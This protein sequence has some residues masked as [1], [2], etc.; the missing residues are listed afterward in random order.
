MAPVSALTA[1]MGQAVSAPS[2]LPPTLGA[3]RPS[4]VPSGNL[5]IHLP[6][7]SPMLR[8]QGRGPA[9]LLQTRLSCK[10]TP[11]HQS[12]IWP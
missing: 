12:A 3:G 10:T 5:Y 4:H 6:S 9:W 1:F 7:T 11:R 8:P 2:P